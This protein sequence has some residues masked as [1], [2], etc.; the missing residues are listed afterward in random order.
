MPGPRSLASLSMAPLSFP[1]AQHTKFPPQKNQLPHRTRASIKS[2]R[3]FR[4]GLSRG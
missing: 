4:T 1:M 2:T 3:F